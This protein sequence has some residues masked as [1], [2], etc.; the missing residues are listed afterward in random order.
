MEIMRSNVSDEL[1]QQSLYGKSEKETERE[2][3]RRPKLCGGDFWTRKA[4]AQYNE[5]LDTYSK[6]YN[7]YLAVRVNAIVKQINGILELS[8]SSTRGFWIYS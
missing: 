2:C 1:L 8:Q 5:T 6:P 4:L 3:K 7:N